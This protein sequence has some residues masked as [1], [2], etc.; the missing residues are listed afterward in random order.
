MRSSRKLFH[1][2]CT[3]TTPSTDSLSQ[4]RNALDLVHS[5]EV[6]GDISPQIF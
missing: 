5:I 3:Y 2:Q 4:D 1:Q 6:Y